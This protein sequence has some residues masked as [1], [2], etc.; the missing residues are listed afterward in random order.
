MEIFKEW[1][2]GH[3]GSNPVIH[4]LIHN[5]V[6]HLRRIGCMFVKRVSDR[7]LDA[8]LGFSAGVMLVASF[9]SLILPGIEYG[10]IW[11]VMIG[12]VIGFVIRGA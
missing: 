3:I 8:S 9:T 12:I 7:S 11:P 1:F 10:G 2:I 6:Q 4:G 5:P